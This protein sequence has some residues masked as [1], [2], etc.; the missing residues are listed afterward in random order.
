MLFLKPKYLGAYVATTVS[1]SDKQF[2]QELGARQTVDYKTQNFEDTL[3]DYD[4][5]STCILN[6]KLSLAETF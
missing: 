4:A 1:T 2:V 5:V 6:T 3:H